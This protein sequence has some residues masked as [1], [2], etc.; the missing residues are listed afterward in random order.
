MDGPARLKSHVHTMMILNSAS[1][2]HIAAAFAMVLSLYDD[3][4]IT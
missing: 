1:T 2:I 4:D 3:Q